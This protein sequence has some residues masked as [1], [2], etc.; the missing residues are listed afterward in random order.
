MPLRHREEII[1]REHVLTSCDS[2]RQPL[3]VAEW[4]F[5][6]CFT[7]GSI[8]IHVIN[9]FHRF[10]CLLWYERVT[11]CPETMW[12]VALAPPGVYLCPYLRQTN[13]YSSCSAS[14]DSWR[15][16]VS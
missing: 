12:P 9:F 11:A 4:A 8:A 5:R 13:R 14:R 16:E 15:R 3:F 1:Y 7:R 2:R 10:P 6:I